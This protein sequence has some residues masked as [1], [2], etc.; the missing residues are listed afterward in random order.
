MDKS[1]IKNFAVNARRRLREQVEQKAFELGITA[2]EIK[3]VEMKSSDAI[4][5]GGRVFNADIKRQRETLVNRIKQKGFDQVMDEV[6]YTWFNRFIALRFMEVNDYLDSGVRVFSNREA[7]KQEPEILS[8][9]ARID[10]PVNK[11]KIYEHLD[12]NESEELFK[13][14]IISQCNVLNEPLPFMFEKIADYTELLFPDKLLNDDSIIREMVN[15]IAEED[16]QEVEI[17]GWLYQYYISEKK[18]EVFA[19]LKKNIK[20]SKENIPAATQLFTPAWI[21][22][23]MV[24]N[25]LGKLW[26]EAHPDKDLQAKWKYYLEPAEQ[27]PEVQAELDKLINKQIKPEDIKV[28]DPACGSGHI[29]VY[30]FE[31]L[32]EIYKKAGYI[33]RDIPKLILE[34]NLYGLDIDDRAAQLASFAVMMKARKTNRHVLR[35]SI[36][37]NICAIQESNSLGDEAK[38]IILQ[39]V[40]DEQ[41]ARWQIDHLLSMFYDA[42]EYGS[43]IEIGDIDADFWQDRLEYVKQ[44]N[45]NLFDSALIEEI[46]KLLPQLIK[47]AGIMALQY[48][49]VC[50]NP[51]YMGIKNINPKLSA[52]ISDKFSYSKA[53]LYAVFIE[54]CISFTLSNGFISMI[55]QNSWMFLA[56][57]LYLRERIYRSLTLKNMVHLG[58]GTFG[59][60]FG[61]TSF[62]LHKAQNKAFNATYI[63]LI[64]YRNVD[65]K[66]IQFHNQTNYYKSSFNN[67]TTIPGHPISYWATKQINNIFSHGTPLCSLF[68]PKQGIITGNTDEFVRYWY[69]VDIKRIGFNHKEYN[70]IFIYSKKWFPFNK[71]GEYRKWYGNYDCIV[72]MENGGESIAHSGKNNNYRLRDSK[73]YFLPAST[74]NSITSSNKLSVR[75]CNYGFLFSDV[76]MAIFDSKGNTPITLEVLCAYLNS[77]VVDK[78]LGMICPTLHFNQG[79]ISRVPLF[80]NRSYEENIATTVKRCISISRIDWD[81]FEISWDFELHPLFKHR[82][83]AD[84]LEQAFLNWQDFAD[85]QFNQLKANEEELNGIFIDIYG[86]QDELTPEVEEKD[87]TIRKADLERDIRSFI[88]YA[89]GCMMGRYSL[90]ETGLIYAGGEFKSDRYITF[91]ADQDAI[92]PVLDRD[93]FEDDIVARFI[94]FIKTTFGEKNLTANLDFIAVALG[95]KDS[96]TSVERIRKYFLNDFYKDHLQVYKK[97]PI[98]WLFTSGKQKAFNA[99]IYMHRYD[100]D[101]LARIRTDYLH[102]LQGKYE[103]ETRRL[104]E[105]VASS[106][107]AKDKRDASKRLNDLNK[108]KEE[109]RKYDELLRH[110]ADQQIEIDLDDGVVV[111]YAKFDGLLAKI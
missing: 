68:E 64:D 93:Y 43:I 25:S 91:P 34:N 51:P 109:L 59:A 35:D 48:D 45:P 58:Y 16:W 107:N 24:E 67:Y 102:E 22:K 11:N 105:V 4:V 39:G 94:Q 44:I 81:S 52:Y 38:K 26:L 60:D 63:R 100:K 33:E 82:H 104:E 56:S 79:D 65:D 47:Q 95:K 36:E 106:G 85:E 19:G 29:L 69:E 80:Q 103:L 87:V 50:T 77:K 6:A 21:V 83:R 72:N 5:I 98:Y 61:T 40:E 108:Q 96:E 86:L 97:R 92:I 70:D 20:I 66:K 37:L 31:V 28:L 7:G 12:R 88:S 14:L 84:T 30:A 75:Y 41:H 76:E 1:A 2:N 18:D 17:V 73:Y 101:T 3:D 111:N 49:V 46:I 27:E 89:V 74:W 78:I 9:A 90:D 23:Y 13:Y 8:Q 42:K 15:S 55:T 10:L 71:G 57:F 53:D 54:R 32:Y 62:V 110:T 99:L